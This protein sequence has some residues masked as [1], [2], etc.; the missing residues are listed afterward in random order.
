MNVRAPE[1]K[2]TVFW[3]SIYADVCTLLTVGCVRVSSQARQ[4]SARGDRA[5]LITMLHPHVADWMLAREGYATVGGGGGGAAAAGGSVAGAADVGLAL[6]PPWVGLTP[7]DL[8]PIWEAASRGKPDKKQGVVAFY[9]HD[10]VGDMPTTR[11][12]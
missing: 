12:H 4:A 7:A 10:P 5:T 2:M 3:V 9:G 11:S 8:I 1:L 6:T